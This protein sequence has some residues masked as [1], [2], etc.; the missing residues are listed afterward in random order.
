MRF[1]WHI[2]GR[3]YEARTTRAFC[4]HLLFKRKAGKY[5]SH[6]DDPAP[7]HGV[8]FR[9]LLVGLVLSAPVWATLLRWMLA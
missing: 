7:E 9:G 8:P 4:N 1:W 6:L 3:F 5:F 2:A